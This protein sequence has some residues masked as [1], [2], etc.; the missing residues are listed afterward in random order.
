MSS[1]S[2]RAGLEEF[3][4]PVEADQ[5]GKAGQHG[6]HEGVGRLLEGHPAAQEAS[7]GSFR[8]VPGWKPSEIADQTLVILEE[9]RAVLK[10]CGS[11]PELGASDDLPTL[12]QHFAPHRRCKTR[13]GG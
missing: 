1:M 13:A 7:Q 12:N 9:Q 6:R 11:G 2:G 10:E 5:P 4:K 3:R 8:A